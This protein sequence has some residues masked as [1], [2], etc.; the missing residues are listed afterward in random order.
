MTVWAGWGKPTR[1]PGGAPDGP[2]FSRN[3]FINSAAVP[4][5]TG[6]AAVFST[7]L[8]A[9]G[10]NEKRALTCMRR[11]CVP[12]GNPPSPEGPPSGVGVMMPFSSV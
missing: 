10:Q 3:G 11:A 4:G 12:S 7:G 6:T 1:L 2:D 9:S 5:S 8:L